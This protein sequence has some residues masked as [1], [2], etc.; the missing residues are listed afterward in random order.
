MKKVLLPRALVSTLENCRYNAAQEVGKLGSKFV[1]YIGKRV[2]S[3][4]KEF[5]PQPGTLKE[6]MNYFPVWLL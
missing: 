5:A 6:V 2:Y 3:K 4:R 1:H